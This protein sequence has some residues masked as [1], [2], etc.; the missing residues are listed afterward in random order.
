[1]RLFIILILLSA[2]IQTSFLPINLCL[3]LILSRSLVSYKRSNYILGTVSGIILG[4][5][6]GQNI[7]F[8]ALV[9]LIVSAIIH[10][11]KKLPF[12]FTYIT[13]IPIAFLASLMVS[14]LEKTFFGQTIN[15]VKVFI[16]AFLTLPAYIFIKFWEERFVVRTDIKLKISNK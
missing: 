9:F 4:V 13:V 14:F 11:T 10:S 2:F 1:M 12:S 7:G 15:F 3:I 5:L 6:N 8:W 16:E